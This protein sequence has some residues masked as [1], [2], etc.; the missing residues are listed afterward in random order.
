MEAPEEALKK[1]L[2][3]RKNL[4]AGEISNHYKQ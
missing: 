2:R 1:E 3:F 4:L